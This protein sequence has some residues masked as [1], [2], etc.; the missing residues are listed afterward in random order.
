MA[1]SI[2]LL[3]ILQVKSIS[4]ENPEIFNPNLIPEMSVG[5]KYTGFMALETSK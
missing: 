5:S 1:R 3:E 4:G 2:L